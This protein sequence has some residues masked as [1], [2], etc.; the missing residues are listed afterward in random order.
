[1]R[2]LLIAG[3]WKMNLDRAAAVALAEGVVKKAEGVEGVDLIG[4]AEDGIEA[5]EKARGL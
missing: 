5:V 4:E 2:R 3:N 1:M